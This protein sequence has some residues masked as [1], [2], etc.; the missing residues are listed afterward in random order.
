M[1]NKNMYTSKYVEFLNFCPFSKKKRKSNLVH[2]LINNLK[3]Y[4][5]INT[6]LK[7]DEK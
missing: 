3:E 5:T 1:Q 7:L 4:P 2:W 6:I